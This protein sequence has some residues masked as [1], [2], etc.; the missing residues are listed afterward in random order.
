MRGLRLRGHEAQITQAVGAI[1]SA[2]PAFAT[3]FVTLV[4]EVA[5]RNHRYAEAVRRMGRVPERLGC[6]AEHTVYGRGDVSLGRVDLRFSS[7]DFTLLIENKLHSSF[8]DEQL[9]RYEAARRLLPAGRSGLVAITRNVPGSAELD[10]KGDGWLGAIRWAHLADGLRGLHV[11]DEGIAAQWPLLV[12]VLEAQGDLGVT[13]VDSELVRAWARYVDG[14][15][16][17]ADILDAIRERTY[18]IIVEALLERYPAHGPGERICAPLFRGKRGVV[19]I[20][21]EQQIVSMGFTIPAREKNEPAL[22]VHFWMAHGEPYF[23]VRA[24]PYLGYDRVKNGDNELEEASVALARAGF[25]NEGGSWWREHPASRF[26]DCDDVPTRLLELIR[27]D[28][29][30]I[31]NSDLLQRD[32]SRFPSRAEH[33]TR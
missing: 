33:R 32:V 23:G 24:D 17:L 5:A 1:G 4:L 21:R 16:L 20:K 28:V 10:V 22:I 9:R 31:V 26:L 30:A 15:D 8:G 29:S 3:D 13:S 19:A 27:E 25:M 11:R 12:D 18:D 14:R 6:V 7:E 2:D